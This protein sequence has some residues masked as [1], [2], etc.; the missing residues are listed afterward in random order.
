MKQ[1]EEQQQPKNSAR[2]VND[3]E[4]EDVTG[5]CHRIGPQFHICRYCM[6]NFNSWVECFEHEQACPENPINKK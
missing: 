3:D 2:P 4:L 6:K 5:G 1:E